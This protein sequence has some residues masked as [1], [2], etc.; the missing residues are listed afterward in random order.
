MDFA[1]MRVELARKVGP[2][3]IGA[4]LAIAAVG[5]AAAIVIRRRMTASAAVADVPAVVG[6]DGE[7]LPAGTTVP[8][9]PGGFI[10]GGGPGVATGNTG[11]GA[12]TDPFAP[13]EPAAPLTNE[14]WAVAA[15]RFLI[16]RNYQPTIVADGLSRYLSGIPVSTQQQSMIDLAMQAIG[17]PPRPVPPPTVAPAPEPT[18]SPGGGGTAPTPAPAPAPAPVPAPSPAPAPKGQGGDVTITVQ[19]G[20]TLWSVASFFGAPNL[21]GVQR[22]ARY[23]NITLGPAPNY[24]PRP[25]NVGQT[26]YIPGPGRA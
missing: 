16:A 10:V 20:Q 19:P 8:Y 15:Q 21:E 13:D 18:P 23:N 4:W 9:T 22:I 3:P 17:P 7:P 26:V 2:L 24:V 25:W 6:P 5:V 11:Q 1:R 14:D 12:I